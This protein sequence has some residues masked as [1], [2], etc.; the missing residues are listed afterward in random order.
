M[1]FPDPPPSHPSLSRSNTTATPGP[2]ARDADPLDPHA[3]LLNVSCFDLLLIELV[4]LA[5]RLANE[6]AEREAEWVGSGKTGNIRSDTGGGGKG[7]GEGAGGPGAKGGVASVGGGTE[8]AEGEDEEIRENAHWRLDMLGYRVGLGIV[9]RF[10][11]DKPRFTDTL[12]VIKFLCKD[13]WT[14]VFR[15]QIDN[16]KTNHR[17]IYV[18]TD[19]TFKPLSRT[20][21]E[22]GEGALARA[23][24]FL[25]FPSG[26]IRGALAGMGITASVQGETSGLPSATFQIKTAGSRA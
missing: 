6:Q 25:W 14:I 13:I 19:G 23:Q 9:E 21:T 7:K 16:L 5:Y 26:I 18:L 22:K 20:S 11:R 15:K 12:D 2:G 10:S 3:N 1:S 4:P 8:G 17:G 24:P